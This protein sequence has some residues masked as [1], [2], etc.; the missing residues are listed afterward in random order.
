MFTRNGPVRFRHP[1]SGSV[2]PGTYLARVAGEDGPAARARVRD[3]DGHDWKVPM[4]D[5][6]PQPEPDAVRVFDMPGPGG[7]LLVRRPPGSRAADPREPDGFA[8]TSAVDRAWNVS[9]ALTAATPDGRLVPSIE[10]AGI[11]TAVWIAGGMLQVDVIIDDANPAAY[12]LYG[13]DGNL[14]PLHI[15]VNHAVFE[16][17]PGVP[18]LDDALIERAYAAITEMEAADNDEHATVLR[19]MDDGQECADV[20]R[21]LL[22]VTGHPY[23]GT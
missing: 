22:A 14:V 17:G 9:A 3:A 11:C 19:A 2:V 7:Y 10:I 8:G 13:P 4:R 6:K 23:P 18:V 16:T 1:V 20:L 15:E 5:I 21:Q 12:A